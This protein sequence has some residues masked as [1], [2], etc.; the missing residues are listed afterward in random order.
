M[1]VRVAEWMP[2]R[3]NNQAARRLRLAARPDKWALW[4]PM[5]LTFALGGRMAYADPPILQLPIACTPGT[6]CFVQ[7][8]PD[9]D[10]SLPAGRDYMCGGATYHGHDGTDIRLRSIEAARGVEVLAAAPGMIGG[11]RD[12]VSDHLIL[13]VADRLAIKGRECGNGVVVV[14]GD[15][16]ETQ[17][18]HMLSG[19]VRVRSGQHV[20]AGTPLGNVGQS[21]DT[22]FAHVHMT[23]RHNRQTL[24]PFTGSVLGSRNAETACP[25]SGAPE[26]S[27]PLWSA[28]AAKALGPP[29]TVILETG[30]VAASISSE[31]LE[32]GHAGLVLPVAGSEEI[33][34]FARIMHLRKGDRVHFQVV[35][36][37]GPPLDQTSDPSP[38]DSAMKVLQAGRKREGAVWS[39]G[40]Y[41]GH[42]DVLRADQ[43]AASIEAAL[44]LH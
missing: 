34:L 44:E 42:V 12:G 9:D 40:A 38:H 29:A 43:V 24:D 20:E 2:C 8:Y 33:R 36:P 21:G 11:R 10:P 23:I 28:A 16:W 15:G 25:A 6:D 32:E 17:Y 13:T 30:F 5:L 4:L 26:G 7:N 18:C 1:G 31:A 37:S 41:T 22:Q 14:H 3:V 35:F 19:S 27:K 39:A